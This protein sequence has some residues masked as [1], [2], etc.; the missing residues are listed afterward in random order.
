MEKIALFPGSFDPITKGH[1]DIVEKGLL[2]FDKIIIAI[3]SNAK[4]T[5]LFPIEKRIEWIQQVFKNQPRVTVEAYTGLT[6]NFGQSIGAGFILRGLRSPGDFEYE[7]QIAYANKELV[8]G[9]ETVFLLSS[10]YYTNISSTIVRDII[11]NK[12]NYSKFVPEGITF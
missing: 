12:G 8:E 3:G 10:P 9:I 5:N 4:K 7:Q 2:M 6:V 1:V 11:I